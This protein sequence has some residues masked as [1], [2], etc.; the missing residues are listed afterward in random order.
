MLKEIVEILM[1]RDEISKEEAIAR[2]KEC[3]RRLQEE[4]VESGDYELAEEIIAEELGLEPDYMIALL[5]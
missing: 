2:V 3:R 5:M 1:R 4:A